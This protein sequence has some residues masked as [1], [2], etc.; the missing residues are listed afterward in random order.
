MLLVLT[1]A[2]RALAEL[3]AAVVLVAS[4][5]QVQ[6]VVVHD[7]G[8]V[9]RPRTLIAMLAPLSGEEEGTRELVL[10]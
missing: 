7:L 4:L 2:V 10:E 5:A 3:L 9:M 6:L 1:V 8:W